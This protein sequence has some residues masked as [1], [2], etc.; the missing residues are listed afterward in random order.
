MLFL[1]II[2]TLSP[3]LYAR[4]RSFSDVFP[5]MSAADQKSVFSP[6]GLT[7]TKAPADG[8]RLLP[9]GELGRIIARPILAK[10]ATCYVESLQIIPYPEG[11][12]ADLLAVYNAMGKVKNL[13][14]RLYHSATR[15][16]YIPLFENATRIEGP[17]KTDPVPD[18]P[19]AGAV[20]ARDTMYIRVK[21][22]NFGNSYYYSEIVI[23]T[24]GLLYN[25]TNF[26]SLTVGPF[27]VIREN[28]FVSQ[29]YIEPVSDG[30]LVYAA[31]AAEVSDFIANRIHIPSAIEKRL[32][33]IIG[34]FTDNFSKT[35][36]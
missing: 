29:F 33:V 9:S 3:A 12:Q 10:D 28:N 30:L 19:E 8:L 15:D 13:G 21:D 20:P 32:K 16:K 14:G 23:E 26:R 27:P 6:G 17:R 25:L 11:R 5:G 1:F 24:Y 36:T 22:S 34:W 4:N 7:E 35:D 2:L 31:A 18:P